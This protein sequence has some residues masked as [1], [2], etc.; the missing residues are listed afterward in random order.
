M[1]ALRPDDVPGQSNSWPANLADWSANLA[2]C[3]FYSTAYKVIM[4]TLH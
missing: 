1:S 4:Q 3:D 2:E